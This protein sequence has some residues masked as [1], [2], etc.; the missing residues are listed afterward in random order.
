MLGITWIAVRERTREFGTRRALGAAA[1]DV[2]LQVVSESTFLALAGCL[3]GALL[4]WPISRLIAQAAGLTF[5]FSRKA[6]GF[7][8]RGGGIAK[9]RV[10][11][12]ASMEGG[13]PRSN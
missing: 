12:L 2:F 4:S 11:S 9:Y 1:T 8:V 6:G 13:N 5:V 10:R 7:R 3:A